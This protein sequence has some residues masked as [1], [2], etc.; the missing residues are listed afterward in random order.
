VAVSNCTADSD[1]VTLKE[2]SALF[3]RTGHPAAVTT[4]RGWLERH[5][6]VKPVRSGRKDWVS[7]TAM[8]RVHRDEIALRD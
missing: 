5:P 1:M 2:C 6:E 4:L 8:L 7:Y 3:K